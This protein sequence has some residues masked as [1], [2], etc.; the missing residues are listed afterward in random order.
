MAM[1]ISDPH[2]PRLPAPST[3]RADTQDLG[4]RLGW[5]VVAVL[6]M[7]VGLLVWT[8][9]LQLAWT[10]PLAVLVELVA[11]GS[12]VACWTRDRTP[13]WLQVTLLITLAVGFAVRAQ[14]A[15]LGQPS[16][17]TDE[18]A[19]DQYAAQ[20]LMSGHNPYTT[21][22]AASLTQFNVPPM[23]RTYTLTGRSVT[24]LSY[25][26]MSFL[27][28]VPAL[29]VGLK[30]QA[31][32][33]TDEL[34]WIA[35]C[36]IMWWLLP[37]KTR[38]AAGVVL[39]AGTYRRYTVGGV[40]DALFLAPLLLSVHFLG[41]HRREG[42]RRV[43]GAVLL[44][45]ACAVKQTPW[46]AVPFILVSVLR[47]H[48]W[49]VALRD[50]AVAAMT[51]A[52]INL[53]FIIWNDQAW[54]HGI[55]LPLVAHTV[56]GGQGVVGIVLFDHLG[57][58]LIWWTFAGAFAYS[59]AI[60]AYWGFYGRLKHL[61]VVLVALV[62]IWPA[63][64]FGS[65]LIDMLPLA[66]VV[67]TTRASGTEGGSQSSSVHFMVQARWL[68]LGCVALVAAS[69]GAGLLLP[70]PIALKVVTTTS[71]GQLATIQ[72]ITVRVTNRSSAALPVSF[73]VTASGQES[74]FWQPRSGPL[75][76][77]GRSTRQVTLLA[78][79][80]G[81]MPSIDGPYLVDAYTS[82]PA[83]VATSATQVPT[84]WLLRLS[85]AGIEHPVRAGKVIRVTAQLVDQLGN[86]VEKKGVAVALGQVIYGQNGVIPA[87]ASINGNFEGR[88]PIVMHTDA[89]GRV[90]FHVV[91]AQAQSLPVVFEAWV[92][93]KNGNPTG[94]SNKLLAW[95]TGVQKKPA[96][97]K[98]VRIH[99]RA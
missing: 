45:I 99:R 53:P 60:A 68:A 47:S 28:Y 22:M 97:S 65:Y 75:V 9:G 39:A 2:A 5:S 20:V 21:S 59:G 83:S 77:G 35:S 10:V 62:F 36:G 29:V 34:A 70:S 6:S 80:S 30:M 43:L 87:E 73:A 93:P 46:F 95:F 90:Q 33:W 91:D 71:T 52:A 78:P 41:S 89:H 19:F 69:I 92:D 32:T 72:K 48:D 37:R 25:P 42:W 81:S 17:G 49:K 94:Y 82:V 67:A 16:Y 85:P 26:A 86:V 64:S 50:A 54:L 56:P 12:V 55:L 51:F 18:L 1:L 13:V 4:E 8:G 11:L 98:G 79:D 3:A 15:I 38:W 76:I 23:Y 61:W 63:R 24:Q 58:Q 96:L 88:S 84:H 7:F 31:A 27:A 44:G 66:L 57:G 14:L 74:S 40:T